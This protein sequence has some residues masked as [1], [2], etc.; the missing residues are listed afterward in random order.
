[1]PESFQVLLKE[2]QALCLSVELLD[3]DPS[4]TL[5]S[6]LERPRISEEIEDEQGGILVPQDLESTEFVEETDPLA[7]P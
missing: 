1:V 6:E 2:L 5:E 4:I 3:D 7:E